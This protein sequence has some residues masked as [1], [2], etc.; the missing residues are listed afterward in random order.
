MPQ[1]ALGT[2]STSVLG[3]V[4]LAGFGF[5]PNAVWMIGWNNTGANAVRTES[6]LLLGFLGASGLTANARCMS[7]FNQN[8]AGTSDPDRAQTRKLAKPIFN[9]V[10]RFDVGFTS[11]DV[12]GLTLDVD[13]TYGESHGLVALDLANAATGEFEMPNSTGI[14]TAI[15]GLSFEPDFF[16]FVGVDGNTSTDW[17]SATLQDLRFGIGILNRKVKTPEVVQQFS[18]NNFADHGIGMPSGAWMRRFG[19]ELSCLTVNSNSGG[20]GNYK[21]AFSSWRTDGVDLNCTVAPS[22][23]REVIYFAGKFKPGQGATLLSGALDGSD[24]VTVRTFST[25]DVDPD[26]VFGAYIGTIAGPEIDSA[27]VA[28]LTIGISNAAGGVGRTAGV[29][30]QW[31]VNPT[32]THTYNRTNA[33]QGNLVPGGAINTAFNIDGFAS[34]QFTYIC[35]DTGSNSYTFIF[36]MGDATG[37]ALGDVPSDSLVEAD[38]AGTAL[39]DVLSGSL[40]ND[41]RGAALGGINTGTDVFVV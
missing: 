33:W 20:T 18:V 3:N 2:Y 32:S 22:S 12:D 7:L 17:E 38:P 41:F 30:S 34:E 23:A 13:S 4:S 14:F 37:V 10:F 11:Y 5:Q 6:N 19:T 28:S 40:V 24:L 16:I 31:N 1:S 21:L 9:G 8:A 29:A 39:G 15:S 35:T 26:L 36:S 25:P 27:S